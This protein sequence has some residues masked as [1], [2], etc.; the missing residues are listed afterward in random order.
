MKFNLQGSFTA[1][2]IALLIVSVTGI[3]L[4]SAYSQAISGGMFPQSANG[5]ICHAF[6]DNGGSSLKVY[7][8]GT[9]TDAVGAVFSGDIELAAEPT[10]YTT[11]ANMEGV[12]AADA[13]IAPASG[14]TPGIVDN[15][16]QHFHGVKDFG[17]G[18]KLATGTTLSVCES[19]SFTFYLHD[20]V[21]APINIGLIYYTR[22]GALVTLYIPDSYTN[23]ATANRILSSSPTLGSYQ[24]PAVIKPTR[25]QYCPVRVIDNTI[26]TAP[27]LAKIDSADADQI[28][29]Y[30]TLAEVHFDTDAVNKGIVASTISYLVN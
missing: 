6:A 23:T 28:A 4:V 10:T 22:V 7:S 3:T 1:A 27:G 15:L 8:I 18:I 9:I 19:G 30:V 24:L 16:A 17:D 11:A 29:I 14:A 26:Q 25:S 12:I 20:A 5:G 13:Y 2:N 21:N